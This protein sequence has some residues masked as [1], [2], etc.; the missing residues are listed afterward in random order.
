MSKKAWIG[1]ALVGVACVAALAT[2]G[3]TPT[4]TPPSRLTVKNACAYDIWISQQNVPGAGDVTK[5]AAGGS[6][7][8]NIPAQGL[9]ATRFWAKT[10]C[11]ANGQNCAVGQSSP[12]CPAGGCPPP[13]DS[14]LEATWGCLFANPQQC[15]STPQGNKIDMTTWWNASAVDGYTLPYT[16]TIAG[17]DGRA[18]CAPADCSGISVQGCPTSDNLSTNG[19][20]PQYASENEH[21]T[22]KSGNAF[23][24]CFS[25]CAKLTYPTFGGIGIQPPSLPAAA[26]YCCPT[27]P[28]SSPACQAGPVPNTQYVQ[29]VHQMCKKTV[30]GYAYDDAIGLRNCSSDV[31]I[32]LTFGP[33]CP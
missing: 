21:V 6:L 33:N 1:G 2:I 7:N 12:P 20:F 5:L 28:V 27:P 8:F 17:G 14:K 11:D 10:G 13:V 29:S 32:T 26:M 19:Q 25:T 3:R 31:V 4:A 9:A 24:G 30:Y 22:P 18:A 16:I 23:I 15:A